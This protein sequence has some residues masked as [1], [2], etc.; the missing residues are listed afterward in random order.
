[1]G[2]S[3]ASRLSLLH[4]LHLLCVHLMHLL[5]LLLVLLFNLLHSRRSSLLFGQLLMFLVLLLLE[6][7]PILVLLHGHVV[8][9]L[10]VLLIQL[11]VPR[12]GSSGAFDGRQIFRM[13]CGV[14]APSRRNRRSAMVRGEPLLRIIVRRPGMLSLRGDRSTTPAT[15]GSLFFG[16]GACIDPA[17]AAVVADAVHLSFT[18]VL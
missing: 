5:R 11:D 10:L 18:L 13:D 1:M 4:R 12:L 17:V 3:A 7:L 8:L 6:F 2:C 16:R 9:F 14:G 15:S